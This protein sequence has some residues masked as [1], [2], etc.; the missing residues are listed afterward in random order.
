MSLDL[1]AKIEPYLDFSQEV[2]ALH[3][4]FLEHIM[5]KELDNILDV[6]CG[7]GNFLLNLKLNNL[8]CLGIDLSQE[9]IN[10]CLEQ[11]LPARCIDLCAVQERYDCL[12]AIFDVLNYIPSEHLKSFLH[13]A[14]DRLND[15]GYFFFDVNTL[16][17]FD[18]V[19]QGTL[20]MDTDD[21][22]IAVDALY[23]NSEL[24]TKITL[25]DKKD[26]TYVKEQSSII[27][28][29]HSVELLQG[30]LEQSGFIIESINSF[31]LH[32]DEDAD[33]LIWICRRCYKE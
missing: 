17:G 15:G 27:Q 5:T 21:K 12:T 26:D 7:Q 1:Y 11:N 25:F 3:K 22:F 14:Y 24:E 23:E 31:H 33:K 6:G 13:C 32:S 29:Y 8:H 19:A 2:H 20:V 10:I 16:F 30:L 18:E 9:Q 4:V 28:Y